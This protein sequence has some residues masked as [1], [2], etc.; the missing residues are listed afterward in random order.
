MKFKNKL[1]LF[2]FPAVLIPVALIICIHY[3]I[4]GSKIR[5]MQ[6]ELMQNKATN[7]KRQCDIEFNTIRALRMDGVEYFREAI[8]RKIIAEIK[9][10]LTE[11]NKLSIIN[12]KTN[13]LV[14]SSHPEIDNYFSK[15]ME[16]KNIL[17]SQAGI[18]KYV[19]PPEYGE[20]KTYFV[21]FSTYENFDW[22]IFESMDKSIANK[23]F[24]DATVFS[25]FTVFLFLILILWIA[26]RI[27][28]N[29]SS[30]IEFL[31]QCTLKISKN[32]FDLNI[33]INSDDEFGRLAK[34]FNLMAVEIKKKQQHILA[35]KEWFEVVLKGIG[36]GIIVVGMDN[37]VKFI[38][39]MTQN[40]TGYPK[41]E[42]LGKCI[43]EIFNIVDNKTGSRIKNTVSSIFSTN[44]SK[45]KVNIPENAHKKVPSQKVLVSKQGKE[46]FIEDNIN[47]ITSSESELLGAVIIFRDITEKHIATQKLENL[48]DLKT[49]FFSN[50]SHEFRTP[51]H[52][53]Y[54][55]VQLFEL[56]VK[57]K[58]VFTS[59][60]V[61]K[62]I[63]VI[64]Q[65]TLRVIRLSN[66]II[67]L[68]KIDSGFYDPVFRNE[69]IINIVEK[70]VDSI[71]EY[72]NQRNMK[73]S[74][75]SNFKETIVRCDVDI[76]ER[77]LLNLIS[78]AIKFSGNASVI[79]VSIE[80]LPDFIMIKIKDYG[81]GIPQDKQEIIFERY[82]QAT[83]KFLQKSEGSGIGLTL[84]KHLV[85]IHGGSIIVNS[86]VGEGSEFIIKLP[87]VLE[88][89]TKNTENHL[90]N[91]NNCDLVSKFNI[92]FSDIYFNEL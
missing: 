38:N 65:N 79:E 41:E 22:L 85:E 15:S 69:N 87:N 50:I 43:D 45:C 47:P 64:K 29:I 46:Y 2:I 57:N 44:L 86:E 16:V 21:A 72:V 70:I 28:E 61:N 83:T 31:E 30:K 66:N 52:V 40:L 6:F 32:D 51:L 7:I 90:A 36:D 78:N 73:I 76:L 34:K 54:S 84:T 14:Y 77:C 89:K 92:E 35:Q 4:T 49:E 63:R 12:R 42:I 81:L 19:L 20:E 3:F 71:S 25:A 53:L 5:D 91:I 74:F 55:T 67:D 37:K 56:Y 75:T 33:E 62:N 10:T 17:N 88:K 39:N 1:R 48:I 8:K 23:Y 80:V 9:H 27:S 68:S 82:R 24:Y 11:G 60:F 18:F 13:E 26:Y 58:T 59:E